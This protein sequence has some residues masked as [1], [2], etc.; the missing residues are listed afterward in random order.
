[1]QR[2]GIEFVRVILP[3]TGF[4]I[5][6]SLLFSSLLLLNDDYET[7]QTLLFFPLLYIGCGVIATLFTIAVKWLLVWR[8]RPG[9]KPLWSAAVWRNELI[10]ALHEHL[11]EPFFVGALTGTP[12]LSW[13][14]RLLGAGIGR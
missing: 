4:I 3:S 13:Y 11:A 10:N 5:L 2:S 6:I 7:W 8:Y 12:F 9:E 14:F 1:A